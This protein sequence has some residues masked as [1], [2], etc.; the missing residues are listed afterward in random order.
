M[1]ASP[2]SPTEMKFNRVRGYS[3]SLN[4]SEQELLQRCKDHDPLALDY[5]CRLYE[6]KVFNLVY[7]MLGTQEEA[8]DI[9]QDI[10]LKIIKHIPTFQGNSRLYTWICR[11][12]MNHCLN[13]RRSWFTRKKFQ[14]FS[15][16]SSYSDDERQPATIEDHD[17]NPLEQAM[18]R[19]LQKDIQR[20][21]LA[22]SPKLR[23]ILVLR[24]MEGFSYEEIAEMLDISAGT[25]KSRISRAR[26]TLRKLLDHRL[27]EGVTV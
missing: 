9:T 24:D 21:L 23:S 13:V 16:D 4:I 11:I 1:F 18:N 22:L 5:L 8:E 25:V 2:L 26:N 19:E 14:T 7:K 6:R 15:V 10:F 12:T 20:S 3:M 27:E 17:K